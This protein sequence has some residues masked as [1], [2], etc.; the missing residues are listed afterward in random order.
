VARLKKLQRER[1]GELKDAVALEKDIAQ[2]D[3]TLAEAERQHGALVSTVAQAH[4][5][6]TLI[7][8][9]RAPLEANLAG[10]FLAVRNSG[11]QGVGAIVSSVALILGVVLEY[12]LPLLFWAAILFLPA[13]YAWRRFRRTPGSLAAAS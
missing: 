8:D 10:N 1:R 12:G 3:E 9:Y 13:R 6:F 4:I 11:I 2:A 7:E 5:R